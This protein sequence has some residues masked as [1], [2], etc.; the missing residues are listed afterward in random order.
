MDILTKG[1]GLQGLGMKGNKGYSIGSPNAMKNTGKGLSKIVKELKG[2][3]KMHLK[4]SKEIGK[5]IDDMESPIKRTLTSKCKAAAKKKFDTY[6]SAYA[7]IWASKQQ[8]KG[9]C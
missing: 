3:S 6:P 2:A 7:N 9:K 5:H 1:I 8:G 4:Q